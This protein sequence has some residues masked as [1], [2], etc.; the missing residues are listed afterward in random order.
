MT[1]RPLILLAAPIAFSLLLVL[2][3]ALALPAPLQWALLLTQI[4]SW[5]AFAWWQLH[6]RSSRSP[7]KENS[8]LLRE[9]EQL[10][11]E[12]RGFIG[13]EV[14]GS[15]AEVERARELIRQAVASLGS[16]F[17]A[18]NGKSRHQSQAVSRIVDRAGEDGSNGVDVARFAQHA[19]Q[20]MEQLVEALEQ[21]SGQSNV[22]VAH[23]DQMA[24]HLDG[25]FALLE[26]VK[27]IA[28][29]TNLL[30]LNAA[31]EAARAG[32][33]GRGFAVVASEVRTLA[34]RSAAAAKEV[35]TLIQTSVDRVAD[36]SAQ[37]RQAGNTMAEI[38]AAVQRVTTIMAD[39]SAASREQSTGIEQVN[40]TVIQMDQTT[41][42]NAALVEEA[43]AAA[44]AMEEQARQLN[45]AVAAFRTGSDLQRSRG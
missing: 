32:E 16:S 20:R 31:I 24:Q 37:V 11:G 4:A 7:N 33:A 21:V 9:Q 17:D 6:Q 43:A 42:Q 14:E 29:Q 8:R 34:Q 26:D 10:L 44:H 13:S 38:I 18:M 12:L 30:A 3:L 27:S 15:R 28:D 41:Q 40:Q 2:S 19:S 25:I 39:I 1:P 23:I 5:G 22:T 35:K 36:G 45:V